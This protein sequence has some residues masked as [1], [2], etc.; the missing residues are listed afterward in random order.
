MNVTETAL[1]GCL[2]IELP[3]HVDHR[4]SFIKL[5]NRR[6]F[7]A[8]DITCEWA[9][10]FFSLSKQWVVRGMHFQVPPA[11]HEKIVFVVKGRVFDVALDIR[12]N[13]PTYGKTHT[14]VLNSTMASAM[15]LPKGFAHGFQAL[16]DET[17]VAYLVGT[18]HDPTLDQ[19]ILWDSI[20]VAW[21]NKEEH[22]ISARDKQFPSLANFQSP[23]P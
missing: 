19:G 20:P 11:D 16:E 23:F 15:Y 2:Y 14:T 1:Q 4:G 13:S 7:Q 10:V 5:F 9:E 18:L 3:H 8:A 22:I 21:P 12:K 6:L 17:I